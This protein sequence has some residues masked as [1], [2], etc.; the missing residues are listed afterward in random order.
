MSATSLP[1]TSSGIESPS[2][3]SAV[4][5]PIHPSIHGRSDIPKG[6]LHSIRKQL[7]LD[8]DDFERFVACPMTSSEYE[9]H[10]RTLQTFEQI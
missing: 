8:R 9:L 3:R 4:R 2:K 6:T 5:N 7:R 1:R 10:L